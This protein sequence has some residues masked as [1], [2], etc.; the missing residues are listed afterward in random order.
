MSE[1][2]NLIFHNAK[3]YMSS[4]YGNRAVISTSAGNTS[5]FHNGTD[6][7][8]YSV[9]LPQYAIEDGEVISVGCDTAYGNALYVWVK[10]P[11]LG[12]K[13]LHYHLDSYKVKAG[14]KVTK[15]TILG[16]TG[17]T[18]FATGIHLH[19][20]L[21]LLSGGGYIDPEAWFEKNYKA[22]TTT[23]TNGTSSTSSSSFF[24]ARGYFKKGDVSPN[25]G[26]IAAFMRKTFPAYTSEKAL[27]NTYGDYIISAVTEF[28][29]RTGLTADGYFGPLTLAKLKTYGF[30]E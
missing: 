21:K 1:L 3:H 20:G 2:S 25:V 9:K 24:P 14:Q 11:R 18:G 5:S 6:Y 28:Q 15:D 17:K 23:A 29:K 7:A 13:M 16:Y 22:P 10:Y 27:G 12:V 4:P 30:T 8:T 19:L 26:K